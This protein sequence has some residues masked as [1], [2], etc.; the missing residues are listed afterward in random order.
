[1]KSISK[2]L[3][4]RIGLML[5]GII[6]IGVFISFLIE[7]NY[8][9]DTCSFMVLALSKRFGI[10]FGT[11]VMLVNIFLFIPVVLFERKLINIGTI[12]NMFFV[13]YI[14]DFCRGLWT[15]YLPQAL[16]TVQ[17][18]RTLTFII[19][20]IPL[21]ISVALYMNAN[22]GLVPYDALPTIIS[23]RSHLPFPV[24][25]IV[26]DFTAILIGVIAGKHLSIA[27]VILAFAIGPSAAFIG[28]RMKPRSGKAQ[29][30]ALEENT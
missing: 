16:F 26:W 17:P 2:E 29:E 25:R 5:A 4:Q 22:L 14:C 13:G 18:Y 12:I 30:H 11:C 23:H 19:A 21:L 9:T 7:V 27:T 10:S 24:V 20:L 1:M 6:G 28:N 15:R 3:V 8:G